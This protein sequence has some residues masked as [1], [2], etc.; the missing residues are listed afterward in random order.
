[1]KPRTGLLLLV[2]GIVVLAGGWVF[3]TRTEPTAAAADLGHLAFPGLAARLQ[4]AA[5]VEITNHGKTLVIAKHGAEWGLADRDFY[6]VMGDKLR[7]LLTGLTELRLVARRTHDPTELEQ[8]GL[9]H[10]ASPKSSADLL[11]VLDAS[12]RPIAAMVFG[13]RKVLPSADVPQRIYVRWPGKTQSW[14]AEGTVEIDNDPSLWLDR[15]IADIQ[16]AAIKSVSITTPGQHLLFTSEAGKLTLTSPADHPPLDKY[17]IEDISHAFEYLTFEDVRRGPAIPGK[18]AGTADFVTD[19][20]TVHVSVSEGQKH[21][22]AAFSATGP[23]AKA[24]NA[25]V[26]GWVYRLG[27]WKRAAFVPTLAD[28]AAAKK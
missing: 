26:A 20:M 3:G 2:L 14:L 27:S 24:M 6:P 19:G 22:W 21:A 12:G 17:K 28:L 25:S 1:M 16:P 18:S 11:R 9:G 8:L 5:S 4:S 13:H 7:G 10:P 15:D 23:H